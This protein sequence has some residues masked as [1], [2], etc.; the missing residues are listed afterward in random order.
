MRILL[1]EA[2][3]D[4]PLSG[5]EV[6]VRRW[7]RLL[8]SLGHRVKRAP[9][10]GDQD[11]D[12][13]VALHAV[14]SADSLRRW[15]ER[16]PAAPS[17]VALTGTDLYPNLASSRT[18]LAS[19]RRATRLVVLQEH[20]REVVPGA[21]RA[22]VR[23]IYQSARCPETE[24]RP[25]DDV[26]EVAFLCHMRE[27]KDPF[28]LPE[29]ARRLPA[30]SRIRIVH[31]GAALEPGYAERAREEM[32][33]NPR[34]EWR[35][36]VER[37]D[38]LAL[39]A[40]ARLLAATSRLEGAGNVVSEA[41]ACGVPVVASAAGGLVGMLGADYP[42]L[43]PVGDADALADRLARAESDEGFYGELVRHC[44]ARA[45]RVRP[46]RERAAWRA[47]LSELAA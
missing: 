18:A 3:P 32:A 25:R 7:A 21:L 14:R 27:V 30:S 42:G 29:A 23:V 43:F 36:E 38:A 37:E 16:R 41:L 28:L 24:A 40:R 9:S 45:E 10:Y 31:V 11:A 22:K 4:Q 26:F 34:Y 47:L 19:A 20:G 2:K 5:N 46:D 15:S 39:L 8:R 1:I 13:L 33:D 17:V 35:G 6:T 12:L 44:E